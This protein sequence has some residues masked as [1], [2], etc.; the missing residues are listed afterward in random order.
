MQDLVT[1]NEA[2]QREL[3]EVHSLLDDG[4]DPEVHGECCPARL[5][6]FSGALLAGW[7]TKS[8]PAG[9]PAARCN[10]NQMCLRSSK[11][12]VVLTIYISRVMPPRHAWPKR[13][14]GPVQ[15]WLLRDGNP[16][17]AALQRSLSM[18]GRS[19]RAA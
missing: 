16:M 14:T 8:C 10:P 9:C 17:T 5:Q 12:A 18:P 3:T 11:T 15:E 2:M 6:S 13:Q 1:H 7:Q 19:G 4:T